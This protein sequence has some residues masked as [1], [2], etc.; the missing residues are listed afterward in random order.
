LALVACPKCSTSLRVPDG[1]VAAVRCPKCQ[2][3]FQPPKPAKPAFE[4]VEDAPAARPP[5]VTARPAPKP[6]PKPVPK[7]AE[8]EF[9]VVDD[10]P[11]PPPK[12]AFSLDAA[13]KSA[14]KGR[15][16]RRTTDDDDYDDE[17][18]R[19]RGRRRRDDD[20]DDDRPRS[21]R[22]S[23]YDDEDDDDRDD[24]RKGRGRRSRDD[25]DDD[26]DGRP[27][28]R[29]AP[30]RRAKVAALLLSISFWL[31]LAT[32]GLLTLFVIILWAGSGTDMGGLMILPGL[33]G[34]GNWIVAAVGLGFLIAGPARARGL[35][36]AATSVAAVHLILTVVCF[37]NARSDMRG[38]L[39]GG[40]NLEWFLFGSMLWA[41]DATLPLLFYN[42]RGFGDFVVPML[43]G[44]CEV[45]RLILILLALKA[46]AAAAKDYGAAE[47]AGKG[48]LISAVVMGVAAALILIGVIVVYEGKMMK[49]G[50][51]VAGAIVTL[52]FLGYA[53]M[54]IVPALAANETKNACD[55]RG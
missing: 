14:D 2:T 10:D 12:K 20:E 42:S 16:A 45:A 5:V 28:D 54:M 21:R 50:K 23:R 3:V 38:F 46:T 29:R 15:S 11:A 43:A 13:V 36:I 53:L 6:T 55:R 41:V 32:F 35:A 52:V 48:V 40:S 47:Q 30:F 1:S 26:Y 31:Y 25:Y 7:P 44:M 4:V 39:F 27:A 19:P 18:D 51:H 34:L 9:E 49:S 17:D 24:R 33:L 8:P 37:F 22:R